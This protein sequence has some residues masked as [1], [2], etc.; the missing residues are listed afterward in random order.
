MY[1]QNIMYIGFDEFKIFRI[2]ILN[3]ELLQLK[4]IFDIIKL[5]KIRTIIFY[6]KY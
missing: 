3:Y 1:I 6:G 5:N 4:C 2:Y